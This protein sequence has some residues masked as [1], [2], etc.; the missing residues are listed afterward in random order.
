MPAPAYQLYVAEEAAAGSETVVDQNLGEDEAKQLLDSGT[1]TGPV[2]RFTAA[3]MVTP[4]EAPMLLYRPAGEG[5]Q[6]VVDA[7][8]SPT[9]ATA[10]S[11]APSVVLTADQPVLLG[12]SATA[13]LVESGVLAP[14]PTGT[15]QIVLLLPVPPIPPNDP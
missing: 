4:P 7:A 10:D 11:A 6:L 12:S 8:G 15:R 5:L 14:N 2:A 3:P 9:G 13:S 1:F